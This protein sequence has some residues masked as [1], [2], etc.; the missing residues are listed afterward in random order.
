MLYWLWQVKCFEEIPKIFFSCP[1]QYRTRLLMKNE[2]VT[3]IRFSKVWNFCTGICC[4]FGGLCL[5]P[6]PLHNEGLIFFQQKRTLTYVY[7]ELGN[8]LTKRS[9]QLS[10]KACL[11]LKRRPY[12]KTFAHR[13]I[14]I[15]S[16]VLPGEPIERQT[17]IHMYPTDFRI[18]PFDREMTEKSYMG[19]LLEN[20]DRRTYRVADEA[21]VLVAQ[22]GGRMRNSV[23]TN[24]RAYR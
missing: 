13:S 11:F 6:L 16:L 17:Y 8:T 15:G 19:P 7:G 18:T 5:G 12:S 10:Q 3:E 24:E 23:R 1:R 4:I 2:S 9:I 22:I 21:C 20:A 14:E